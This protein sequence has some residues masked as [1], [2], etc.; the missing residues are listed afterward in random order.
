VTY[1]GFLVIYHFQFRCGCVQDKGPIYQKFSRQ[2][3]GLGRKQRCPE[4]GG[5]ESHRVVE[6]LSGP[7]DSGEHRWRRTSLS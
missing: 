7:H 1:Y 3:A 4:H 5:R 6:K 2:Y